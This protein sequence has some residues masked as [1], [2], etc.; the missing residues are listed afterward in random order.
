MYAFDSWPRMNDTT[1]LT[2]LFGRMI[3]IYYYRGLSFFRFI[4][5]QKVTEFFSVMTTYLKIE[6]FY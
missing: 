5:L 3:I 6:K 4:Q 2:V 1:L